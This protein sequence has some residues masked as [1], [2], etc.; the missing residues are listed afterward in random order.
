MN[1]NK[2]KEKHLP[3]RSVCWVYAIQKQV[4]LLLLLLALVA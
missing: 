4:K 2:D 1:K 3:Y